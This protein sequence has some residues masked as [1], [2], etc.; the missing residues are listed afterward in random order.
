M[1]DLL[2]LTLEVPEQLAVEL[3]PG[4]AHDLALGLVIR[5]G[6]RNYLTMTDQLDGV[7]LAETGDTTIL[8]EL[9]AGTKNPLKARVEFRDDKAE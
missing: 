7:V 8:A 1:A 5:V 6:E 9:R 3:T 4:V 2:V